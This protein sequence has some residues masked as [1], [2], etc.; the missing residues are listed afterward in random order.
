MPFTDSQM[1]KF[2]AHFRRKTKYRCPMCRKRRFEF[3]M[4]GSGMIKVDAR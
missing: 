4:D 1:D 2:E 3:K